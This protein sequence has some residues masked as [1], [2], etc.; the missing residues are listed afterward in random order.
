[1][2]ENIVTDKM[3]TSVYNDY[4]DYR[5]QPFSTSKKFGVY[6]PKMNDQVSELIVRHEAK[7]NVMHGQ[8]NLFASQAFGADQAVPGFK[9]N[10]FGNSVRTKGCHDCDP[11]SHMAF[12]KNIQSY[13]NENCGATC[14][15]CQNNGRCC[16]RNKFRISKPMSRCDSAYSHDTNTKKTKLHGRKFGYYG[17]KPYTAIGSDF[18]GSRF[19]KDHPDMRDSQGFPLAR[20]AA[21]IDNARK[22]ETNLMRDARTG[23]QINLRSMNPVMKRLVRD[24]NHFS[25]NQEVQDGIM[26]LKDTGCLNVPAER[27]KRNKP[28]VEKGYTYNDY[29]LKQ[30]KNGYSRTDNGG[31][32]YV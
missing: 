6:I 4:P 2:T 17:N 3:K 15:C 12:E 9:D 27:V 21:K 14:P 11:K 7:R 10:M 24:S 25:K 26:K 18:L 20:S 19:Y 8:N 16:C 30:T 13:M 29:H 31:R 5:D 28:I 22:F 23:E 32:V 1:M